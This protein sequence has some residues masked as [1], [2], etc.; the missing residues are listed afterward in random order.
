MGR[1]VDAGF[2]VTGLDV[3]KG[4]LDLA[5]HRHPEVRLIQ[6]DVASWLPDRHYDL[7]LAWDSTFHLPR[8]S[9]EPV[10]RVLCNAL[11]AGGVILFTAGGVEGEVTGTMAGQQFHYTSLADGSWMGILRDEGCEMVLLDHD[12]YPEK[13]VVIIAVKGPRQLETN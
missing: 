2:K 8:E 7:V 6:G 12:Q 9:Q 3:S 11:T 4:M 1:L 5:Q 13:H 10:L